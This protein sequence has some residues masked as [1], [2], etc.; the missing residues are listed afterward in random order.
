MKE[1]KK[2]PSAVIASAM[3]HTFATLVIAAFISI[4]GMGWSHA[5]M[6]WYSY[7]VQGMDLDWFALSLHVALA[8]CVWALLVIGYKLVQLRRSEAKSVT[9][10]VKRSRGSVMTET[11]IVLVPFLLLTSGLAQLSQ[12]NITGILADLAVFQAAR[13]VWV[14][15][16]EST[17]KDD[18]FSDTSDG[19]GRWESTHTSLFVTDRARSIAA[20]SL[21]PTAPSDY[22][23]GR[24]PVTGSSDYFRR[25]RN[26]MVGAFRAGGPL[27]Q[28]AYQGASTGAGSAWDLTAGSSA[29]GTG[30]NF[31]KGF[32]VY[33]YQYRSAR[34]MTQ[35][36]WGLWNQFTTICPQNCDQN[37]ATQAGVDFTYW[38]NV[39]F[40]WF[41]YIWG[42]RENLGGR[43]GFYSKIHRRHLFPALPLPP[44]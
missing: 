2:R 14:W 43:D 35:A 30:H 15:G 33:S 3:L 7:S 20:M 19:S 22:Y 18:S 9:R 40:P 26:V 11:L 4:P 21:A 24:I 23:T 17:Q 36:E 13:A 25:Q 27:S 10:L 41:G 5:K 16:P 34:K 31:A 28:W 44:L 6:I 12:L 32:D 37:N 1:R 29:G 8:G 39:A 42:D 38:Y